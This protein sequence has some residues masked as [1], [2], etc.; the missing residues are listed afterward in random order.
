MTDVATD[1]LHLSHRERSDRA[2]IRV[3]GCDFTE[4]LNPLTPA[5]SPKGRGSAPSLGRRRHS[6]ARS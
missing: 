6:E 3:R 5:L 2:A 4:N 1:A